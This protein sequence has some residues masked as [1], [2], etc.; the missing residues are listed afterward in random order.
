MLNVSKGSV[1][2]TIDDFQNG[3][4]TVPSAAYMDA[5]GKVAVDMRK[6]GVNVKQLMGNTKINKTLTQMGVEVEQI[7]EWLLIV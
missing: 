4:L 6:Q 7:L 3:V 5:L 2:N 1:I